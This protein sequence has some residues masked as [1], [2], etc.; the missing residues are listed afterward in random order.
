[1]T[2]FAVFLVETAAASVVLVATGVTGVKLIVTRFL[3]RDIELYKMRLKEASDGE[4]GRLREAGERAVRET[5]VPVAAPP[6]VPAPLPDVRLRTTG[7]LFQLFDEATLSV[8]R[9]A[10]EFRAEKLEAADEAARAAIER[11]SRLSNFV[12]LNRRIFPKAMADSIEA[13]ASPLSELAWRSYKIFKDPELSEKQTA[14]EIQA[15]DTQALALGRQ[16]ETIKSQLAEALD[17]EAQA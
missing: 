17:H 11:T 4:L 12:R 7:D 3:D 9:F 15:L 1:M 14:T 2:A 8:V 16:I 5:P 6:T 13:A 10:L